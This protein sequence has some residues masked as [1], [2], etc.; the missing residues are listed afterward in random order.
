MYRVYEVFKIPIGRLCK[1]IR[2]LYV[3]KGGLIGLGEPHTRKG[4]L[5]CVLK[6]RFRPMS[7]KRKVK[8]KNEKARGV[9]HTC[10]FLHGC[11][12]GRA[13]EEIEKGLRE[14]CTLD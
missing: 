10:T 8:D 11:M 4:D 1:M 14:G 2:K 13:I 12:E 6:G 5:E 9:S 3:T 7:A